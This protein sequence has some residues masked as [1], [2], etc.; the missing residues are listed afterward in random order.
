M[1]N[2]SQR[3]KSVGTLRS[4]IWHE[5]ADA[6]PDQ[7]EFN[8]GFFEGKQHIKNGLLPVRIWMLCTIILLENRAL[9][10]GET[11]N[12]WRKMKS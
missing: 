7:G 11:K 5:F 8:V 1:H 3:F 2:V 12:W 9:I 6:V 10:C 4:A